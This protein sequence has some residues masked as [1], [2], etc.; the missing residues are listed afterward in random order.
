[1]SG[2]FSIPSDDDVR[3]SSRSGAVRVLDAI[4]PE[5]RWSTHVNVTDGRGVGF[6][7]RN[8]TELI[9]PQA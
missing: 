2:K 5:V 4:Q 1:M 9:L 7:F 3:D 8:T 6:Y